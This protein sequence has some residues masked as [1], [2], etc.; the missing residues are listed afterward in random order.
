MNKIALMF[1]LVAVIAWGLGA[2]A[3]KVLMGDKG[4]SPWT[5]VMLKMI[6]AT[7]IISI[8]AFAT[9]SMTEI[10]DMAQ[11]PPA[12]LWTIIGALVG[13]AMLATVVGQLSYYSALQTADASRVVPLTS[14]YPLVGALLA[15]AFLGESVTAPKVAGAVL[16]VVGIILLSGALG[17]QN[18]S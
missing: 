2:V 5:A 9:G 3:D 18:A 1:C 11:M 10:R 15:V 14:T 4:L 7:I 16:I 6:L 12:Q 8:Y 17:A 13:T